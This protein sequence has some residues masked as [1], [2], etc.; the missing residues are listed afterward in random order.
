MCQ[1]IGKAC[2]KGAGSIRLSIDKTPITGAPDFAALHHLVVTW[3]EAQ[4]GVILNLGP[5]PRGHYE[6]NIQQQ[7]DEWFPSR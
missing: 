5:A 3:I 1:V 7:V 4:E 6:R 2:K